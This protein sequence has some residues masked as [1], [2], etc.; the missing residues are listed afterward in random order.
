MQQKRYHWKEKVTHGRDRETRGRGLSCPLLRGVRLGSLCPEAIP[1]QAAMAPAPS[2]GVA[3]EDQVWTLCPRG[4]LE[5]EPSRS[6]LGMASSPTPPGTRPLWAWLP[7]C[8]PPFLPFPWGGR[9][10]WTLQPCGPECRCLSVLGHTPP[11]THT[12][13]WGTCTWCLQ[14]TKCFK[15]PGTAAQPSAY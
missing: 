2:M 13:P 9:C 14:H 11:L 5:Q 7:S 4:P 3:S 6:G 15:S 12:L 10:F 1:L 8:S